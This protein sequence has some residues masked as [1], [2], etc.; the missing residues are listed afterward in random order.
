MKQGH[1][2]LALF[3]ALGTFFFFGVNVSR[4]D[5]PTII[6]S[7]I[8]T[9]TIWT[10][11]NSPYI[12]YGMI[13]VA[14]P[15]EIKPGTIIKFSD[16]IINNSSG[17]LKI[18][19][20]SLIAIGAFSDRIVF[21]ST[22][23]KNYGGDT[24]IYSYRPRSYASSGSWSGIYLHDNSGSIHMEN[25]LISYASTGVAYRSI[26]KSYYENMVLKNV[27]LERNS[28]GLYLRDVEP[29][30]K[31]NSIHHNSTG[32]K[33]YA[34]TNGKRI[35]I[36]RNSAIYSN[37][38][39][40][41]ILGYYYWDTG[42]FD[43]RDN[44]WGDPSGPYSAY[45]NPTGK[46]NRV[47]G[48]W[49]N[50]SNWLGEMPE[51]KDEGCQEDCF[52]N[53]MF[54]PGIKASQLYMEEEDGDEDQLWPPN[55][56]GNDLEELMLDAD[57]NS[58]NDVYTKDVL[59]ETP[60]G[61]NIYKSFL[62]D[63]SDLK[64]SGTINDFETFVYDW[65]QSVED[66]AKNGTP[67][68][69]DITKMALVD[70]QNLAGKSKSG[71]V[72][73]VAHS[74]GGLLAKAMML[75]LE[76]QGMAELVDKIIFVGSP[77]MGTPLAILSLLYGYDEALAWGTLMSREE[78]RTLAENMP[79]AY[80]LLPSQE[81]LS[82]ME[83]PFINFSSEN[84]RYESFKD[85][86]G[87]S[88]GDYSEFKDFLLAVRDKR[89]KPEAD[90]VEFENV[91]NSGILKKAG[92]MH[93]RID[94]WVP[95][96]GTEVIQIAGW[97]IDTVSG[98]DFSEKETVKCVMMPGAKIPACVNTGEYEPMYE[99]KF[100]VDGDAVVVTPSALMFS[101][102]ENAKRY[103]LDLYGYNDQYFT[104]NR[105]HGSIFES[106]PVLQFISQSIM[107]NDDPNI[108]YLIKNRPENN[109]ENSRLRMSLYS[110]LD[111]H[112]YDETG[113]HTGPIT[114][115]VGGEEKIVFEE[116]IPNSYYYQMGERKYVGFPAGEKIR[117]EMEGY[118]L[119]S[120]TLKLEEIRET[121]E[122]EEVASNATFLDLP[123]TENSIISFEIPEQGLE[124]MSVLEGDMDGDGANEYLIEKNLDGTAEL[125]L[126]AEMISRKVDLYAQ[127]GFMD[128]KTKDFLQVKMKELIHIEEMIEKMSE[129]EKENPKNNQ[130]R[131]FNK[132]VDDLIGFIEG[133]L[134]EAIF[135]PAKEALIKNLE[136]IKI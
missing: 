48:N 62:S 132:K 109:E 31:N 79:G 20:S 2:T 53:V 120:F 85:A 24:S 21:T 71:K 89:E 18:I 54:L 44:W 125:P 105:N 100:T 93:A 81:Y 68:E 78:A 126:T 110:P 102:A 47:I 75:E 101:E 63:L 104:I 107:D 22:N 57:G 112:L 29:V 76:R 129:K 51:M 116:N 39:G 122:G 83:K 13:N 87:E 41:D 99:P 73:L 7:D 5:G 8:S 17:G 77:Q 9:D 124:D 64:N 97:G 42:Y 10:K 14:A 30:L 80:G 86:Y 56:F 34:P 52:S 134:A 66:V 6:N 43:A 65:R 19:D 40:V 88:I 106:E 59:E 70:L 58:L 115:E 74:N 103:W 131:L 127:L 45:F 35:P 23:D 55:Y 25:V 72:T 49:S 16:K 32:I 98:V 67:Y 12:I 121:A 33:V 11:E 84:T 15:L 28:I 119:G 90:E 69:G 46:G 3:F 38:N 26:Y 136:S 118:S 37:G 114:V 36:I 108:E 130:I 60:T 133:K 92:E 1:R 61:S 96:A 27:E 135:S 128:E 94:D 95:P 50:F 113:N 82:R 111:I 117:V 123:V 4:A 91:L